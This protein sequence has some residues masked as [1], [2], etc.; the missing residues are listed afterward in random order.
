MFELA[1]LLMTGEQQREVRAMSIQKHLLGK[2]G[3]EIT[4]L[5][6]GA[7][8]IGG[9]QYWISKSLFEGV[10]ADFNNMAVVF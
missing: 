5:G 8:A 9:G 3:L 2:S 4:R 6:I 7:W 1:E 10:W